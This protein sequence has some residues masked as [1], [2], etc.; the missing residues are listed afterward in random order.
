M[1]QSW[2]ADFRRIARLAASGLCGAALVFAGCASPT[3][4]TQDRD[5]AERGSE[6]A[7]W[8]DAQPRAGWQ[9]FV[10]LPDTGE[11]FEVYRVRPHVFALYEPGQFE[12]VISY[13]IVGDERAVLLDTGLGIGDIA[14]LAAAITN[15]PITVVNSHAHYDHIGGNHAFAD[16][17][18]R[19][20]TFSRARSAGADNATVRDYLR[21][22]WL[23]R[24]LPDGMSVDAYRILSYAAPATLTDGERIDLGGVELEVLLTPGHTDDSLCLLD[25]A[26]G[27]LFTGDTFYPAPLYTHLDGG[28][29]DAYQRSAERLAELARDVELILPGHNEPVADPA[30]LLRVAEA[31]RAIRRG[32]RP[33]ATPD[34]LNE[35]RFDGFSILVAPAD[36]TEE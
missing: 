24:P 18:G 13:L 12:E 32:A 17:R 28:D 7:A 21:G 19:A 29:L 22:D 35:Y 11:W 3:A 15:R 1:I 10:A 16:I 4:P 2:L 30:V 36:L 33:D 8:W 14:T 26:N 31:F 5:I 23:A 34:G 27:L 6:T 20:T 9:A 25:R